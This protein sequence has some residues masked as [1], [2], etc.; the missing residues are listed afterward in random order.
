VTGVGAGAWEVA[1]PLYQTAGSQLEIDYYAHNE[2]LQLLA[3]YGLVG[4]AFLIG[5]MAYLV[6]AA[7]RT[8]RLRGTQGENE[9]LTRALVLAS[10]F[11]FL[12]VSN[13]GFPWRMATT[14]AL[15]A[16]SLSVLAASDLRLQAHK[17]FLNYSVNW[18]PRHAVMALSITAIGT[19][20]WIYVSQQAVL[21]ESKLTRAV[22]IAMTISQSGTPNDPRW[23]LLKTDMLRPAL[24][25]INTHRR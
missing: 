18:K 3:E 11:V 24:Q 14:G 20:I 19:G 1:A 2:V 21:C 6:Y 12:L 17:I 23:N 10:I 16:L 4:W 22:K 9:S 5:L 7:Y 15:F 13:A 25:E 8:W